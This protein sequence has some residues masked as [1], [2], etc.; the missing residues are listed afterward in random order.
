MKKNVA[1]YLILLLSFSCSN[2]KFDNYVGTWEVA[3]NFKRTLVNKIQIEKNGNFYFAGIEYGRPVLRN[4]YYY[5]PCLIEKDHLVIKPSQYFAE[6]QFSDNLI[7]K[8]SEIFYAKGLDC[9][10]FMNMTFNR[11]KQKI[12]E[13]KNNTLILD[14]IPD[15]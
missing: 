4:Q 5:Y 9:L 11:S 13:I 6:S 1:Y 14:S 3:P 10:F 15:R 7:V 8:Q 2:N 12:F